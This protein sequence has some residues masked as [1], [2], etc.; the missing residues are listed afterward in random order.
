MPGRLRF[1]QAFAT[2]NG[3]V[4]AAPVT[5]RELRIGALRL[6]GIEASV[7]EAPMDVSLLGMAFLRRLDGWEVRDGTLVM[8]W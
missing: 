1:T 2:A 4:R 3:T 7:N 5:L 8:R 6:T